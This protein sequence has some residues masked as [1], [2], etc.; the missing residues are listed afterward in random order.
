M[1]ICNITSHGHFFFGDHL[2][3]NIRGKATVMS[4]AKT[5]LRLWYQKLSTLA[6]FGKATFQVWTVKVLG[7]V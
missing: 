1:P 3:G 7:V 4:G 6:E 5:L 2:A